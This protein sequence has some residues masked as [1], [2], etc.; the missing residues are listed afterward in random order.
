MVLKA[1]K[2][3]TGHVKTDQDQGEVARELM[4]IIYP[5][6]TQNASVVIMIPVAQSTV[7]VA[8][9]VITMAPPAGLW[10]R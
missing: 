1:R 5:L 4:K 2:D 6:H 10:P 9:N 3:H 7:K 8:S